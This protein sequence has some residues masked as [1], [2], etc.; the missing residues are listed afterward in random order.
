VAADESADLAVRLRERRSA[1]GTVPDEPLVI[2]SSVTIMEAAR[3]MED[4]HVGSVPIVED[5]ELIGVLTEHDLVR[6]MAR[7][8]DPGSTIAGDV[9]ERD[10]EQVQEPESEI[11]RGELHRVPATLIF[12]LRDRKRALEIVDS[13][14]SWFPG[15][16]VESQPERWE[17]HIA[18]AEPETCTFTQLLQCV[19]SR[20]GKGEAGA[21]RA[22]IGGREYTIASEPLMKAAR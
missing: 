11:P 19:T 12:D 10:S 14:P 6:E 8:M 16:L 4:A 2:G 13:L 9:I 20:V 18:V 22:I 7:G 21:M 1:M 17:V 15:H 3:L 5:G